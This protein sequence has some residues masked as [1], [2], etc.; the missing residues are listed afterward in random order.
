M[1]DVAP[2]AQVIAELGSDARV[3]RW[4][5]DNPWPRS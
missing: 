2:L 5:G 4:L 1:G 3:D